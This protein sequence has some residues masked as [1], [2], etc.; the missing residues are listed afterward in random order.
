M[1]Y[2]GSCRSNERSTIPAE[3]TSH[4]APSTVQPYVVRKS[5]RT[6]GVTEP[7]ISRNTES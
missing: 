7:A 1:T 2:F 3:A 4:T 5:T 6:S